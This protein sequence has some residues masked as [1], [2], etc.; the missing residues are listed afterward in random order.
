MRLDWEVFTSYYGKT[1]NGKPHQ[2]R[3]AI[4]EMCRK[5]KKLL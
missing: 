2:C 5:V 1:N 3:S 4:V